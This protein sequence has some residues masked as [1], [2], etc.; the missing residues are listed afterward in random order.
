MNDPVLAIQNGYAAY[1][2]FYDVL[3]PTF[4][5]AVP[6]FDRQMVDDPAGR[7]FARSRETV[8]RAL[9]D[10]MRAANVVAMV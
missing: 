8:V 6:L 9:A 7:S 3:P 5:G 1:R 10:S 4:E 2:S